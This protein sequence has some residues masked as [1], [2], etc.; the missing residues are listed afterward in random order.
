VRKPVI[1]DCGMMF[2]GP[3]HRMFE[4]WLDAN[5]VEIHVLEGQP[6]YAD[7]TAAILGSNL[8][9]FGGGAD[10]HPS[11]YGHRNVASSC[12]YGPSGRD[13]MEKWIH[14]TCVNEGVPMGICRGSQLMCALAG[15]SLIQDVGDVHCGTH[16]IQTKDGREFPITSTHHQ[17]MYP[18][19]T[20][21]ELIA[22]AKPLALAYYH[23]I[24]NFVNP[25]KEAEIVYFK[26][27][28]ALAIQGHPEYLDPQMPVVQYCREL[29]DKYLLNGAVEVQKEA[30]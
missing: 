22:W 23:D 7:L 4:P 28:G 15:G 21:H 20:D 27:V 16:L 29:V 5:L 18:N 6:R 2:G 24:N 10:V 26:K 8:V 19:D 12:G 11:L 17:M 13:I 25:E 1:L 30:A 3:V 9:C 14:R